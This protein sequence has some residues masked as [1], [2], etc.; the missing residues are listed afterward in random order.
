MCLILLAFHDL[1]ESE[2]YSVSRFFD[3]ANSEIVTG[4]T[5]DPTLRS[6]SIWVYRMG[7]GD[8]TSPRITNKGTVQITY[9]TASTEYR[10]IRT[11]TTDGV[12]AFAAPPVNEWHHFGATYDEGALGNDPILYLDG[13]AQT[14]TVDT[15]PTGTLGVGSGDNMRLG[16][17]ATLDRSFHGMLAECAFWD[18]LLTAGEMEELAYGAAANLVRPASL[19]SYL[20]LL[21]QL[22]PELD[23]KLA[24]A[25]TVSISDGAVHPPV[26]SRKNFTDSLATH[27]SPA[28][29][30]ATLRRN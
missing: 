15:A 28:V 30:A 19:V 26:F 11:S 5:S 10:F 2:G 13:I 6:Y 8:S 9:A 7:D 17:R 23:R 12:W 22:T 25:A 3:G 20:P 18:A 16:N 29:R 14:L 4:L 1:S 24:T 21:G 27:P